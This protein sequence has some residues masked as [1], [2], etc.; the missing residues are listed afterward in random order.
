MLYIG[1]HTQSESYNSLLNPKSEVS[2]T[3]SNDRP[4]IDIQYETL[5]RDGTTTI[6]ENTT[7]MIG[8]SVFEE[9]LIAA[10]K[11]GWYESSEGHSPAGSLD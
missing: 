11:L 9:I 10:K 2:A 1:K 6:K 7:I 8:K 3:I 4:T 5:T